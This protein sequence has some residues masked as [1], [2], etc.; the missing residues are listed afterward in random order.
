MI[1]ASIR[2]ACPQTPEWEKQWQQFEAAQSFPAMVCVALQLGL[3]FARW[4]MSECLNER[5]Q[6]PQTWPLCECGQ[7]LRSKGFR[8][9]QL[10]TIVG[11]V[12]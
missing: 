7:R 3:L 12:G 2:S 8:P 11:V 6:A 1:V 5:G 4:V 9:R 10:M